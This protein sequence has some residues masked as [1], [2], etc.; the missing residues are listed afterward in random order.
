[1]TEFAVVRYKVLVKTTL[2]YLSAFVVTMVLAFALYL[3]PFSA[4]NS[5]DGN[6]SLYVLGETD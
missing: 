1:M 4:P 3:A 6:L 5:A 2:A